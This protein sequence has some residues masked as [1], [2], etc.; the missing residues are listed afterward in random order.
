MLQ[1]MILN[2]TYFPLSF[3]SILGKND[4]CSG[5][6]LWKNFSFGKV[7]ICFS[8]FLK[9]WY[10]FSLYLREEGESSTKASAV[11]L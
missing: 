3:L 4:F 9:K 7:L 2:L 10:S 8:I 6:L 11:P 1:G 5:F